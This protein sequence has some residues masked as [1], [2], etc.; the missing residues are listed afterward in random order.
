M[1][2]RLQQP[3]TAGVNDNNDHYQHADT[4]GAPG[5]EKDGHQKHRHMQRSDD[6]VRERRRCRIATVIVKVVSRQGT[7]LESL[8]LNL[9]ALTRTRRPV[10][11]NHID[12]TLIGDESNSHGNTGHDPEGGVPC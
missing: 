5:D 3:E 6:Y 1:Q 12:V 7:T 8:S 11:A 9:Q 2:T 10:N 4:S